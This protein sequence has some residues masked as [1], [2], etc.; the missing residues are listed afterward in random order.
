MANCATILEFLRYPVDTS[1]KALGRRW[2]APV[3]L[4]ILNGNNRF[5][6]LLKDIPGINPR[7]FSTR[8]IE[9]QDLGLIK[10]ELNTSSP[11]RV[12]YSLTPKGE[13]M[14]QLL[15]EIVSFSLKWYQ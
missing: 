10:R 3:L 1:I 12:S 14:R 2:A 13:E 11:S 5:N 4:E 8:L 15:R 9:F 7:T 6:T